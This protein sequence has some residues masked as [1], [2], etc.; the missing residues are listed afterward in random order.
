MGPRMIRLKHLS[1]SRQGRTMDPET[2]P[3]RLDQLE[4]RLAQ[5]S[6]NAQ[7]AIDDLGKADK[8]KVAEMANAGDPMDRDI[9]KI[10]AKFESPRCSR[11]RSSR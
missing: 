4:Q 7:K 10:L 5:R 6:G 3:D 11:R 8:S 9:R 1:V 2:D